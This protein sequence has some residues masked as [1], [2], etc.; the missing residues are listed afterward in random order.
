MQ[1]S[2]LR[3]LER[4]LMNWTD[5]LKNPRI[6]D[7]SQPL[8]TG[9]PSPPSHP[10]FRMVLS[11]RH[12]DVVR[13][14]GL[15]SAVDLVVMCG[16]SGTHIDALGHISQDGR[17]HGG[18]E[19][20]TVQAG[21]RL[22]ELGLEKIPLLF[23]PG[24]LLDV[25]AHRGVDNLPA[26]EAIT[27]DELRAVAEAQG[28]ELPRGGV[29]LVRSGWARHWGDTATYLGLKEGCPG[30]DSSAAEWI[31]EA[32]PRATGHDS[33][34]YERL[35]PGAGHTTLPVHMIMLVKHGIHLMENL[36]LEQLAADRVHQFLFVCLP[37]KVIGGTG[38]PVRPI[39]VTFD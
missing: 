4:Y 34:T 31:A 20:S 6:Y 12:G 1:R 30:P 11:S 32:G 36:Y 27:G 24:V 21:G 5:L 15:S 7:L 29:V 26:G 3:A 28:V 14:A 39:A 33:M 17:L 25:A 9:I 38:S 2:P 16:H 23:C 35:A 18:L 37:L 19:A 22:Q 8:E 10:P 13:N